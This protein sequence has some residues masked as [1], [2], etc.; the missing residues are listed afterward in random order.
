[1]SKD[2]KRI[3]WM[4]K[5]LP[6]D[7]SRAYAGSVGV[8]AHWYCNTDGVASLLTMRH[9]VHDDLPKC[10]DEFGKPSKVN[11]PA[12]EKGLSPE[13]FTRCEGVPIG[14]LSDILLSVVPKT[15]RPLVMNL[16]TLAFGGSCGTDLGKIA[17]WHKAFLRKGWPLCRVARYKGDAMALEYNGGEGVILIADWTGEAAIKRTETAPKASPTV[18]PSTRKQTIIVEPVVEVEEEEEREPAPG[19]YRIVRPGETPKGTIYYFS[20][21]PSKRTRRLRSVG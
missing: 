17:A 14:L 4:L 20:K 8:G 6:T 1:M 11:F 12:F 9:D 13:N 10:F 18:E 3:E 7:R 21:D 19:R 5:N 15:G 2:G 16:E